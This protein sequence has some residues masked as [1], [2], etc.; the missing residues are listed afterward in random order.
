MISTKW[1]WRN[2]NPAFKNSFN[3]FW[4]FEFAAT[5]NSFTPGVQNQN[6]PYFHTY[7][8]GVHKYCMYVCLRV[9]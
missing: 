9:F 7:L 4:E 6:T 5:D 8:F 1:A 2:I 3:F